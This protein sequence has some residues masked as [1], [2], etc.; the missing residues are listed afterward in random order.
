MREIIKRVIEQRAGFAV[1]RELGDVQELPPVVMETG[2][3]WIF[4]TIAPGQEIPEDLKNELFLHHPTLHIVGLW[5]DGGHLEVEWLG[6]Q[7][8]ELT[9]F[10]L[11]EL[12]DLLRQELQ[13]FRGANEKG[14][15]GKQ[16]R[17]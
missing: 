1:V 3:E 5:M 10:T 12:T 9:G 2:V 4:S 17:D 11:D 14:G 6:R 15:K 7:H 13:T 8:K 16:D